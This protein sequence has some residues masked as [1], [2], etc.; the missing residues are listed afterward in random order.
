MGYT[1]AEHNNDLAATI[2]GFSIDSRTV[3]VGDMF[4][5]LKGETLNG[6]DFVRQ[7]LDRGASYV[8]V[9]KEF[10]AF[11]DDR[12]LFVED[13]LEA[14]KMAARK[15]R[16]KVKP[17]VVAVTG[18]VGKTTTKEM[19]YCVLSQRAKTLKTMGNLNTE[20]GIALTLLSLDD[21]TKYAVV[22][23][24]I[25]RVGEMER[26]IAISNPD[27]AIIT[28]IGTSHLQVF[29]SREV[30][31]EEK[32]KVSKKLSTSSFLVVNSDDDYLSTIKC[33]DEFS[34]VKVGYSDVSDFVVTSKKMLDGFLITDSGRNVFQC[35]LTVKGSHYVKDA[36]YVA[37]LCIKLGFLP[38]EIDSGL[39][40]FRSVKGRFDIIEHKGM[41]IVDDTY[42]SSLESI[43]SSSVSV[44]EIT[45]GRKIAILGDVLEI[46]DTPE[47][48]HAAIGR[49]LSE[50][51]KISFDKLYF[52]GKM[53]RHAFESYSGEKYHFEDKK[54]LVN[55][56]NNELLSGDVILVKAS[57]GIALDEV[58]DKIMEF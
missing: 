54:S 14:L 49:T 25:D 45:G 58:V 29:G 24:G 42:N 53:M 13:V 38:E 5:A 21:D 39:K 33:Q 2:L 16:D 47:Q 30:I 48:S 34:V 50:H 43:I 26:E 7:A 27:H 32:L 52:Y 9:S 56:L 55:A 20:V 31:F 41:T 57:R 36:S 22:E 23:H 1:N 18:S 19:L 15:H 17:V 51:E 40:S 6:E 28:I 10:N 35:N 12:I 11:K 8:V 4:F 37:A 44:S 3:K 46:S